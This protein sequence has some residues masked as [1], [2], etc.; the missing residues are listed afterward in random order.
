MK[1]LSIC[2][3]GANDRFM[4]ISNQNKSAKLNDYVIIYLYNDDMRIF[5]INLSIVKSTKLILSI[6]FDM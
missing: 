3:S 6:N 5:G 4:A 1:P 2:L